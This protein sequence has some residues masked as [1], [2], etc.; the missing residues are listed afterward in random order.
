MTDFRQPQRVAYN[1][2]IAL[3]HIMLQFG[4]PEIKGYAVFCLFFD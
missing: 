1:K 2:N 3:F 4:F